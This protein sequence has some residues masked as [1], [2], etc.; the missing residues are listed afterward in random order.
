[1]SFV[2]A[3]DIYFYLFVIISFILLGG[4]LVANKQAEVALFHEQITVIAK[5]N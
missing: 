5:M 2:E 4:V 3:R 1:M